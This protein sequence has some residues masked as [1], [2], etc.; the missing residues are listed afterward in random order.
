MAS[1]TTSNSTI[2]SGDYFVYYPF[3]GNY[4]DYEGIP[5]KITNIQNQDATKPIYVGQVPYDEDGKVINNTYLTALQTSSA[6]LST[7]SISDRIHDVEARTNQQN[8]ALSQY[9]S[10][11]AFMIWPK[12]QTNDIYVKRIEMVSTDTSKPLEIPVEIRFNAKAGSDKAVSN[13]VV[14]EDNMVLLFDKVATTGNG[15]LKIARDAKKE[16]AALAYMTMLP[17]TYTEDSYKFVVYYTENNILKKREIEGYKDLNFKSNQP[18]FFNIELDANGATE[19]TDFDIYTETEFASAV[20]KSNK[21]TNGA[22]EFSIKQPITLTNAYEL[23]SAVPVTFTGGQDVILSSNSSTATVGSL[24]FNSAS[25]IKF[26]NVIKT[27]EGLTDAQVE[28]ASGS[29]VTIKGV[30][31]DVALTNSGTLT[32]S[33]E[34][35]N[36]LTSI[37]NNVDAT[38]NVNGVK[39]SDNV[40]ND[41]KL[42]VSD[43]TVDGNVTT[44]S[45]IDINNALVKG[46]FTNN[47]TAI[48]KDVEVLS[49]TTNNTDATF[50][51]SGNN[52][53]AYNANTGKISTFNNK[54]VVIVVDNTVVGNLTNSKSINIANEDEAAELTAKGTTS[55]SGGLVYV[56]VNGTY[57]A[58]G[59]LTGLKGD[60]TATTN[61]RMILEGKLTTNG[62]VTLNGNF[63]FC[64]QVV[65]YS[66]GSWTLDSYGLYK[67]PHAH[68]VEPK[69]TNHG[70]VI[71]K[72]VKNA[73]S[74]VAMN[75]LAKDLYVG[76]DNGRLEWNGI[77]SFN[78]INDIVK[79]GENCWATDLSAEI[80]SNTAESLAAVV[81][82]K[83]IIVNVNF[84]G[85]SLKTISCE[86]L[87]ISN[88]T[89]NF[90]STA[91]GKGLEFT[92]AI[93]GRSVIN[94]KNLEI[95]NK[96]GNSIIDLQS[97]DCENVSINNVASAAL[98]VRKGIE[99][100]YSGNYTTSGNVTAISFPNNIPTKK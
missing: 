7:F 62:V 63:S 65:N 84:G 14:A 19:V 31:G 41:G 16:N 36:E 37:T 77:T 27:A 76:V 78:Y 6:H 3:D 13:T 57:N 54:G 47:G 10:Y 89:V 46:T 98:E 24:K 68:K 2:F 8:F 4:A 60:G 23:K 48:V 81:W 33:N 99:I 28:V 26:D 87:D 92:S 58:E 55:L 70:E 42:T 20:S 85:S 95:N 40:I 34:F 50:N 93:V 51:I 66:N 38:L 52:V 80:F 11:A 18:V 32:V 88:L 45:T 61:S 30:S 67:F 53:F 86:T 39:V 97:V 25:E 21:I 75:K 71:V 1:F 64:G 12:N 9:T 49:A 73:N 82:P 90:T 56:D 79:L 91:K 69:F 83:N 74:T 94:T 15:G 44:S 29:T 35:G 72:G 96:A 22:V 5:F 43:F 17:A 59:K 100:K